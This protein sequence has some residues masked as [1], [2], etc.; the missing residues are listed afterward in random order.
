[1]E[2]PRLR[3]NPYA[4]KYQEI[5]RKLQVIKEKITKEITYWLSYQNF[6]DI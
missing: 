1:M 2:T 5:D 4:K 3:T 6:I